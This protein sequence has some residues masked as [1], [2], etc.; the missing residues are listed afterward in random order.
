MEFEISLHSAKC[1][2]AWG[3]QSLRG[4]GAGSQGS[5]LNGGIRNANDEGGWEVLW[6][7]EG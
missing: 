4:Q 3:L 1:L 7:G 6:L 2:S 5:R